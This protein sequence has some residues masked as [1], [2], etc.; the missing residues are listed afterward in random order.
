MNS[1]KSLCRYNPGMLRVEFHC[2][3]VFSKDSLTSPRKLVDVCCRIGIDRGIITGSDIDDILQFLCANSNLR[4]IFFLWR[5]LLPDPK[6]DFARTGQ[7][8]F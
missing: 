2:H 4:P 3:T 1:G 8:G 6:D 7:S 5:P